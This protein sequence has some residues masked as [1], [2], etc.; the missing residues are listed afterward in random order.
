MT[1][2]HNQKWSSPDNDNDLSGR[3]CAASLKSSW[4]FNNCHQS[5]PLGVYGADG[6]VWALSWIP[7]K[8]MRTALDAISF[9][10]R[11]KRCQVNSGQSC[12]SCAPAYYLCTNKFSGRLDC[13]STSIASC[14]EATATGVW[15]LL[16]SGSKFRVWCN[17]DFEGGGW[18]SIL[19]RSDGSQDFSPTTW[20]DYAYIGAGNCKN[21]FIMS[22]Y[23]MNLLT[24]AS[25]V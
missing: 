17:A 25:V 4:W 19:R 23:L 7:F 10:I 3:N 5:N 14:K 18:T 15:D 24:T 11:N 12:L 16:I 8:G 1:T 13:C 6:E 9:K 2:Y 22:L 20:K 21:E